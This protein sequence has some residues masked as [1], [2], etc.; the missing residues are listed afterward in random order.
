MKIALVY[1]RVNK[2]GGAERVLLAL[3]E[4]FPEAVLY[5]SVYDRVRAPWAQVFDVRT[6]FL[7]NFPH[8]VSNHELYPY[9]MPLAFEQFN[10]DG[11]DLVISV[12][13]EAA[14]GIITKPSTK[15]ICYCL[16]PTRYL[17]NGY[18]DYF[19]NKL[20]RFISKPIVN[21][22]RSWDKIAARK[23]DKFIAI[24]SEVK[25]RIKKYYDQDS[26]IIYPAIYMDGKISD[27]FAEREDYFLAVARLVE[28]KRIDLAI[29]ACNVLG[30]PL[31]IIGRGQDEARLRK[32]AGANI[33]FLGNVS[34]EQLTLI[35]AKARA[36][37][38][39]GL[40]DFGLTVIEAQRFGTP[41]VAFKGGGSMET[42]K[43][44]VTGLFF[45]QQNKNSLINTL[46]EF[47]KYNFKRV[48]CMH[49]AN[50][51][52]FQSFKSNILTLVEKAI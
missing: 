19:K 5:T 35:Y 26:E 22:L 52:S 41:V 33:E 31:K 13:S 12:T 25:K 8:I 15:H 44:R 9:L 11:Y 27:K 7:Q 38:N 46:T 45:D 17:W 37:I 29:S 32:M 30:L 28:Y 43:D 6:S 18:D 14:K 20:F 21:Y 2:W 24:S 42:I 1:D 34:D 36:L 16:T 3:H 49:Q 23:P 48:D 39:P 51:F 10:F 4:I 40:E 50:K 47:N